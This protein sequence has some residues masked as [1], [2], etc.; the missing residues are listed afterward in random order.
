MASSRPLTD[1]ELRKLAENPFESDEESSAEIDDVIISDHDTEDDASSLGSNDESDDGNDDF[2]PDDGWFFGK[3]LC[4]KWSKVAPGSTR[5]RSHNI[6]VRLPG[7]KNEAKNVGSSDILSSWKLF[8]T[9]DML[10][11]IL[12]NTNI[13]ISELKQ[14]YGAPLPSFVKLLDMTE[15]RAFIG[16]LYLSGVM[17]SN[18]ENVQGLFANDGTGRDVFRATMN[19]QRFLFIMSCLRFDCAATRETRKANDKLAAIREYWDCFIINCRRYYTPGKN[20]T[21]DEMLVPFRGRCSF[22]MYMPK[23]PAKYGLKIQC[24]C[25]SRTS[26][27]CDA[28]VYTGKQNITNKDLSI[29][30]QDVLKLIST[31]QGTHRNITMDNWYVSIELCDQMKARGLTVLGTLKQNKPQIP[32][33]FKSNRKRAVASTLFGHNKE[34]TIC[35]YVPKKNRAVVLLSTMHQDQK[36]DEETNKPDMILNYN[37]TKGGV[38]TLD[39]LCANYSVSR[40]TRRWPMAIF[41]TILNVAGVNSA[42]VLQCNSKNDTSDAT[43]RRNLL[44]DLGMALVKSHIERRDVRPLSRELR[45]VVIKLGGTPLPLNCFEVEPTRK[46]RCSYCPRQKDTKTKNVCEKCRAHICP[47]HKHSVCENCL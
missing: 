45:A 10:E 39:Q 19:F 35:S 16:L 40:R 9:E 17:K 31:I 22:R 28:F 44:K 6:I 14:K 29:P 26:Y 25:D 34:K 3:R 43:T 21:I 38:D 24:L 47:M 4:Y 20:V 46:A 11:M 5:T 41:S 2:S 7:T 13:K 32:V 23:K 12:I 8:V 18:H 36:I 1:D 15:L 42:I 33:E 37:L 30:T 27:L